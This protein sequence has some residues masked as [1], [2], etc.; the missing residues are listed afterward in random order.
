[1][2]RRNFLYGSAGA[3]AII[4]GGSTIMRLLWA[5]DAHAETFEV[6]RDSRRMAQDPDAGSIQHPAGGRH[7]AALHEPS[8]QGTSRRNLPLRGLRPRRLFVEDEVRF[9]HGLAEFLGIASQRHRHQDRQFVSHAAHRGALPPLRWAFRPYLR[10]RSPADGQ[11]SLPGWSC[12]DLQAIRSKGE[13]RTA[14]LP[15]TGWRSGASKS[16]SAGP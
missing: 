10:R 8:A 12:V 7:G 9:R 4:A 14:K 1:M 3:L 5:D 2:N 6:T 15:P 13:L 11:A 16:Q